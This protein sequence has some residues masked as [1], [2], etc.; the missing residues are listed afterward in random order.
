MAEDPCLF[1]PDLVDDTT[2]DLRKI[3]LQPNHHHFR[4]PPAEKERKKET[5]NNVERERN[6]EAERGDEGT[7]CGGSIPGVYDDRL[8][9]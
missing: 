2:A 6:L 4:Q 7:E 1:A 5:K 8:K 9:R 3:Y